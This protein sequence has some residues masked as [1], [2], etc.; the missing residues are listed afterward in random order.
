MQQAAYWITISH[1]KRWTNAQINE[2]IQQIYN[3]NGSDLY[4][5]F[6][7][8]LEAWKNL[9]SID[10]KRLPSLLEAKDQIANNAFLAEDL[11]NQ[12]FE[13]IPINSNEYSPT[14]KNN[15]KQ[16][17]SPPLLYIKGNKQLLLED[18]IAI[19]GS[20]N[21]SNKGL[22][23][24]ENI[25][26]KAS[27]DYKVIVSGFAKG[28][29]KAALDNAIK[30]HG[31]SIIVLPQGVMTFGSGYK[32]YYKHIIEGD[33]LV[34]STF[35]P[36]A[37]W[38]VELAMA[39]NPIIYGLA[40]EIFVADSS[41][42]GGT[43]SGVKDGLRKGRTIYVRRTSD[44]ENSAN[45]LL[46]NLGGIAVDENGNPESQRTPEEKVTSTTNK[47]DDLTGRII[48]LLTNA[49]LTAKEVCDKLE[50]EMSPKSMAAILCRIDELEK[51]KIG[52]SFKYRIRQQEI[53]DID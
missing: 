28:I 48:S 43:W 39:R 36:K 14:M 35:H 8:D 27:E 21:A 22:E 20:R 23:F 13:L 33:V 49:T 29:D 38:K 40:K 51:V 5:F 50:I 17:Y 11:Y 16:A 32:T 24:T 42:S 15:L 44:N 46:I 3:V 2:L 53:F 45:N 4:E 6:S 26:K 1:L 7:L 31:H 52:R 18:S 34:L 25:V 47:L 19:V 9:Y 10:E 30:Y 41:N 12:G 37:P